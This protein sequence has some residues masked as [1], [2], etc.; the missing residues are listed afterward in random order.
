VTS[1]GGCAAM[2]A[3]L[4][5][6]AILAGGG[7]L[8]LRL[9]RVVQE[10]GRAVFVVAFEGQTDADGLDA[11]AHM[12]TRFGAAGTVIRRL[13]AEGVEEIVFAGPV[14]RPSLGSV[15]PDLWT[16]GFIARVG[17]RALG[18]DGLL[19]AIA[20]ALED[21]GFRVRGL[22]DFLDSLLTL[23]GPVGQLKPDETAWSDIARGIE[24]ARGLGAL[25][26]GQGAVVQQGIV[27]A[28]EAIEGTD[29]MLGRCAAVARP[30]PGGVLVK[31]A[32]PQQDR[33][34]D[35][36]TIGVTTVVNAHAAGLRGIAVEAGASLMVER[37]AVA[38]AADRLGLFVVGIE[39]AS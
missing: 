18:D 5:K 2:T 13:R 11:F 22:H 16:A 6:L 29:A 21:E 1:N 7:P 38:Q 8:P 15:M 26:V 27:L 34:L 36:P 3:P 10:Q 32:K 30:G 31:M 28:A 23:P 35:L 12:W 4:P 25:D 24:V 19:K 14:T 33:R 20:G 17:V 9:A 37:G 39:A